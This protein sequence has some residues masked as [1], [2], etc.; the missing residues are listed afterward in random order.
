[1]IATIR[2]RDNVILNVILTP[3]NE[4]ESN[5]ILLALRKCE[6]LR[7]INGWSPEEIWNNEPPT[8]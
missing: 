1:M 8:E 3:E 4:Y 7:S 5:M 6:F 2:N